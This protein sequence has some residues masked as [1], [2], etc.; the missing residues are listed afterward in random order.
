MLIQRCHNAFGKLR[1]SPATALTTFLFMAL[2][3]LVASTAFAIPAFDEVMAGHRKSDA[4]LLDRNGNIIH[5]LR[6]DSKGRR[7]DWTRLQNISPALI[8]AVIWSED[9]RFY[10]HGGVDWTALGTAAMENLTGSSSRGAS[11]I[12]MQ[13]ASM[14]EK[15]LRP[16]KTKRT[17]SQKWDQIN[18][19]RELDA[20]WTKENILEAY[21]NLVTF[22]SELQGID[23]ASRGLFG[24]EPG[25][26]DEKES[27]LLAVL[28]RSPNANAE[29]AAARACLL[30]ESIKAVTRCDDIRA[31]AAGALTGPYRITFRHNLA[32][33]AASRLLSD[34]RRKVSSTIDSRLQKFAIDVLS[35]QLMSISDR[36]VRDGAVLVVDNRSGEILAYIAGSGARSSARHVDGIIAMRQAGSTLKPFLYGLAIEKGLLTAASLL[37]D[38]AVNVPTP[39]GLYIPHN[40]DMEFKGIVSVRTA[41]SSSLNIPAVRALMLVGPED[42]S[43]RLSALGFRDLKGGDYYG[44]S[45]ALGSVDVSL[46]DLVNAFRTLA[47][48]GAWSGMV[49][50]SIPKKRAPK[51]V[52]NRNAA[53]IIS[54]ILSDRAARSLTFGYE[55]PL[56]TRYWTAVKTGTSKDMRDNWCIGYSDRYTVGVWVGNFSGEP[57]WNVSGI[58]GAAPV[59]LEVMNYLHRQRAS[60]P[61]PVPAEIVTKRVVFNSPSEPD[62]DELFIKGTEPESDLAYITDIDRPAEKPAIS[63]P[64]NET[65]IA[66]DPDIPAENSLIFFEAT[67]KGPF[68]WR[69]NDKKI[70]G[71][72]RRVSWKPEYGKY[73]LSLVDLNGKT[74]DRVRFEV[75]GRPLEIN[76]QERSVPSAVMKEE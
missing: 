8:K 25:G 1:P 9:R 4:V 7:L 41:L 14:L 37:D 70:G 67:K 20:S 44:L 15:K 63:Y 49:M 13:L 72:S 55:N 68:E 40:Y 62:R 32:P 45:M 19:A 75:R 58:S 57:M 59:W 64:V 52:M 36:N 2:A 18:A 54:D 12:T 65:I 74:I 35:Y 3:A 71:N 39:A 38:S 31:L 17:L 30:A 61:R 23:A 46:Y 43:R 69:L 42:F 73:R 60:R 11:T 28:V 10:E 56:S 5:D 48:N 66:I 47:N 24:K 29:T 51:Q 27:L 22:R 6:V 76:N 26:L 21:L 53:F 33:H 34:G 16:R 50:E